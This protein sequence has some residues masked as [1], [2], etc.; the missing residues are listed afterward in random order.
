MHSSTPKLT[1]N[2]DFKTQRNKAAKTHWYRLF[3]SLLE[4]WI[5]EANKKIAKIQKSIFPPPSVQ[6]PVI[7]MP[8]RGRKQSCRRAG[9][10]AC[11]PTDK[12]SAL[13]IINNGEHLEFEEIPACTSLCQFRWVFL[14]RR[15][16]L[17]FSK[18]LSTQIARACAGPLL[19][20]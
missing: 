1:P 13:T 19:R 18:N 20:I 3:Y 14:T 17:S 11:L 6:F 4:L 5:K 9:A 12:I 15:V 7:F 2:Y 16:S 8:S 10:P